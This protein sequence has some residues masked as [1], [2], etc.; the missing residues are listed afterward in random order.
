M[1]LR[2]QLCHVMEFLATCPIAA[3]Q[4]QQHLGATPP[5]SS[6]NHTKKK[7]NGLDSSS[8]ITD[9]N[10]SLMEGVDINPLA[11]LGAERGHLAAAPVDMFS[12]H[13]LQEAKQGQLVPLLRECLKPSLLHIKDCV[14]SWL[15]CCK[16]RG[17][18]GIPLFPRSPGV[19]APH[20]LSL[21]SRSPLIL[22]LTWCL[23]LA[24]CC[25]CASQRG[26]YVSCAM[27]DSPSTRFR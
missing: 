18:S 20:S 14:V 11:Y 23:S 8:G 10:G 6:F 13:D 17:C 19:G 9:S 22:I 26:S 15:A 25:S 5:A 21:P 1:T 4:M 3:S 12:M 24:G 27:T 16:R 7:K 2:K